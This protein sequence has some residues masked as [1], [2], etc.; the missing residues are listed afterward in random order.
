MERRTFSPGDTLV[1]RHYQNETYIEREFVVKNILGE[2]ASCITYFV[3]YKENDSYSHCGVLKEF[4][5]VSKEIKIEK[6]IEGYKLQTEFSAEI[7]N[8]KNITSNTEGIYLG[9]NTNYILMS[10]NDGTSY[11]NVQE[12][13]LQDII[14]TSIAI[15]NAVKV[16]H[17][18]GFLHLDIK[19]DNIFILPETREIIKLFD[20][21]SVHKK[22]DL[23][24]SR[25][26][27]SVNWA[28]PELI[29]FEKN[30]EICEAT[31]IYSIG[32]ILFSKIMGRMPVD[33]EKER[34]SKFEFDKNSSMFKNISPKIFNM[35]T[36][37]FRNTLQ[38]DV[39]RRYQ[40]TDELKEF[41]FDILEVASGKA[42]FLI[43]SRWSI[44]PNA[45]GREKE[46]SEIHERL[47]ADNT[48]FI[49]AMGGIGKSELAKMYAEK[50]KDKYETIQFVGFDSNLKNTIS[51]NLL[52]SNFNES[53]YIEK[54]KT[55]DDSIFSAKIKLFKELDEKTL[56]II[57]N[58]NVSFDKDID[59][60]IT[61]KSNGYKVIFTTRNFNEDFED[62]YFELRA[63]DEDTCL[64]LYYKHY[65]NMRKHR[66]DNVDTIKR[67]LKTVLYNTL[68][69]K[70]M[71]LNC[72]KQRIK[73]EI[74]LDKLEKSE[75][76]KIQGKINHS[77]D[78]SRD[79]DNNKLMYEHLCTIFDM[80]G[81]KKNEKFIMMN[82]SL[83]SRIKIDASRFRNWC[84]LE[85]FSYMNSL[86][87]GGWVELDVENDMLSL[88]HVISDLV[89]EE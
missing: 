31:D 21:D 34:F 77:S 85:D 17:D 67:M 36:K 12:D 53:D 32:A 68:L 58:F 40:S 86:V 73:P 15:C 54:G 1:L 42:P 9:N 13:K 8:A 81:L 7:K 62:K 61:S 89:Y 49:R 5:P 45:I 70:L 69:V 10:C 39:S 55:S 82:L 16:Y 80:T 22:S 11:E 88:H 18:A 25:L 35:F 24:N 2:G 47:K 28:A 66:E 51:N 37:L 3:K 78:I 23:I 64:E 79:E 74:M 75:I 30:Y 60:V 27:Y 50:Y 63:M 72:K 83:I 44:S 43:D 65:G 84:L 26:S 6:F 52:F 71:A 46:L 19:P 59:R 87:E 29:Y 20:F 48:V 41:L 33:K 57:D 76:A 38:V 4:N 56:I 14:K